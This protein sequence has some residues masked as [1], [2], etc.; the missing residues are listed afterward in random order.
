MVLDAV[1]LSLGALRE[2]D[3]EPMRKGDE[4]RYFCPLPEC[5]SKQDKRTQKTLSANTSNGYWHC[6]RCDA[7]GLLEEFR[8][9]TPG[10]QTGWKPKPKRV[11]RE[12]LKLEV[13]EP[14]SP[15]DRD[16]LTSLSFPLD[17]P[18]AEAGR[19]YM[20]ETRGIPLEVCTAARVRFTPNWQRV[21]A[22][23]LFP[24]YAIDNGSRSLVAVQGRYINPR[25]G[26]TPHLTK[27]NVRQG[28]FM[29]GGVIPP[30]DVREYPWLV[31][32]AE[33][34]IDALTL[35]AAGFPAAA[36]CGKRGEK[37]PLPSWFLR[38]L[39]PNAVV[40]LAQDADGAGDMM[41][42]DIAAYLRK[43]LRERHCVYFPG[44]SEPYYLQCLERRK[45][46]GAKDWNAL[47]LSQGL[48]TVTRQMDRRQADGT[49]TEEE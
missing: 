37:D 27:G 31:S 36:T 11:H 25:Q 33:A 46:Q 7:K 42:D 8:T 9:K 20:T 32:I 28:M 5:S 23:V 12:A 4:E 43:Y 38:M 26:F 21:G 13:Y 40:L 34:P 35:A 49:T 29:S 47:A 1:S 10:T 19:V 17:D 22:A 45:P 44:M 6:F 2:H 48:K 24:V 15:E 3:P 14:L 18:R 39:L 30:K 16:H 41:A